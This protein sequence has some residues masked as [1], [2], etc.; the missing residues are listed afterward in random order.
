[1]SSSSRAGLWVAV[2]ICID[3]SVVLGRFGRGRVGSR[4]VRKG[5]GGRP[6][7][8]IDAVADDRPS[9]GI[10]QLREE[11]VH[12]VVVE[13]AAAT[14]LVLAALPSGELDLEERALLDVAFRD[15]DN[16]EVREYQFG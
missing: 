10:D 12:H 5:L 16:Q 13:R 15:V 6:A 14:G 8:P 3:R 7:R 1:M 2:F 4:Q 11:L 9:A